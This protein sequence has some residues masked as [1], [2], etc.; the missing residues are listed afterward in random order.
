[1]QWSKRC[2]SMLLII[3]FCLS[4]CNKVEKVP[5][6]KEE[7]DISYVD[8][9]VEQRDL[10]DVTYIRGT[11]QAKQYQQ[12]FV[13]EGIIE[14]FLVNP[15]DKVEKGQLIAT[16]RC[17]E[18]QKALES[19]QR[20]LSFHRKMDE[21][22][23]K[24]QELE[25]RLR[26]Q[27]IRD[28]QE[29]GE[30][31]QKIRRLQIELLEQQE[32]LRYQKEK[33]MLAKKQDEVAVA[34]RQKEV[35]EN[36]L[37]A[38][39]S[40]IVSFTLGSHNMLEVAP[41]QTVAVIAS[42]NEFYIE[43]ESNI[44]ESE[45][46]RM[47]EMIGYINGEQVALQYEVTLVQNAG[48][49]EKKAI[50][51]I[52][53]GREDMAGY[54]AIV[55]LVQKKLKNAVVVPE[56]T[57]NDGLEG[58]YVYV[59][60][61]K[62]TVKTLVTTGK[63]VDGYVEVKSGVKAGQIVLGYE[64]V[65]LS[66][67]KQEEK[68]KKGTLEQSIDVS[69]FFSRGKTKYEDIFYNEPATFYKTVKETG[70]IVKRGDVL[71][72]IK[73]VADDDSSFQKQSQLIELKKDY[74]QQTEFLKKSYRDINLKE[75][76][77][78]ERC[79]QLKL[80]LEQLEM[81]YEYDKEQIEQQVKEIKQKTGIKKICAPVDGVVLYYDEF[82]EGTQLRRG[83]EILTIREPD[84]MCLGWRNTEEWTVEQE[85]TSQTSD[86]SK[87]N[88]GMHLVI[89]N[90]KKKT[91]ARVVEPWSYWLTYGG[92]SFEWRDIPT[93]IVVADTDKDLKQL[94][95]SWKIKALKY[96]IKNGIILSNKF[97]YQDDDR[98]Y[99]WVKKEN[100]IERRYITVGFKQKGKSWILDGLAEGETV[101]TDREG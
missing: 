35:N 74:L 44:L 79:E 100:R 38:S 61:G 43:P 82:K 85:A 33:E 94:N 96:K 87:V 47:Q 34:K 81:Q 27:E 9:E 89:Q 12:Q 20:D 77:S 88:F 80:Q 45:L 54:D 5:E 91:S 57:V 52:I 93:H 10:K 19:A 39:H 86:F 98:Y 69:D 8:Y 1:M 63:C 6:L 101:V 16:L 36:Y 56:Q 92:G 65:R 95:D 30:K 31:P 32:N 29:A 60:E 46:M 7:T 66:G 23:L 68:V 70:D 42:E 48:K 37:Y 62:E 4:G 50:L 72:E 67:K 13:K 97:L 22:M 99:V 73:F 11:V 75:T 40:G 21:N 83:E 3:L 53:N 2:S 84:K 59:R 26:K 71:Y 24:Q 49:T 18:Q 55:G 90:G 28:L 17:E 15:G 58:R 25:L 14:R 41:K 51:P 76:G 64:G 78:S